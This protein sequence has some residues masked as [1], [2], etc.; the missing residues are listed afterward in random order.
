MSPFAKFFFSTPG[1]RTIPAI[2]EA[3]IWEPPADII[4]TENGLLIHM[5]LP[6]VNAADIDISLEGQDLLVR[7][8][9]RV[10]YPDSR[11]RYMQMEI[12]HG[13]FGR[14]LHLPTTVTEEGAKLHLTN[15]VL[16]IFLP[17]CG[18]KNF[19]ITAIRLFCE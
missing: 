15:G 9:K 5:E 10:I 12:R 3:D 8:I 18:E 7:G 6:G 14:L 13:L 11:K 16:E 4:E 1:T 2:S 17:F 19:V